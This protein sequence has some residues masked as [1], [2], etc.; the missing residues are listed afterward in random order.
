[1]SWR[2]FLFLAFMACTTVA[3]REWRSADGSRTVEAEFAGMEGDKLLLKGK[4]GKTAAYPASAFSNEDQQFARQAQ[5]IFAAAVSAGALSM[6]VEQLLPEGY[7]CRVIKEL[8]VKKDAWIATGA[9]FL[10]LRGNTF[11]TELGAKVMNQMLYHAGSR[12]LQE[13]D[14]KS[15]PLNAYSVSLDEAVAA[16]RQAALA[17][18]EAA[19]KVQ[20]PRAPLIIVRGMALPLGGPHCIAE[21]GM[22]KGASAITLQINGQEVPASVARMIEPLDVALL[23]CTMD[24]GPRK[25]LPR[26][27]LERGQKIIAVSLVLANDGRSF[28]TATRTTGSISRLVG[29]DLFEHDATIPANSK[30]GYVLDEKGD[31]LGLFFSP[32]SRALGGRQPE[33]AAGTDQPVAAGLSD[34]I[35]I[36]SLDKLFT[37][38]DQRTPGIPWSKPAANGEP[39][40]LAT[41]LLR[42]TSLVI[43]A[44]NEAGG[45][46]A[47]Q[48]AGTQPPADGKPAVTGWSLSSSGTRHNSNCRFYNAAN[49]C[50]AADGKPCKVC[51]G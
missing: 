36:E 9:P 16:S 17:G 24:L 32:Q 41:E 23:S 31:V 30:G 40:S 50:Q 38:S 44:T 22:L 45:T 25:L 33:T 8:P 43:T 49:A 3:A 15:T 18:G 28:A 20:E 6:Q 13:R 35:R 2:N 26:K 5:V 27:P 1:M 39:I 12:T 21:A 42:K 48:T 29:E 11:A 37:D 47:P 10:V 4:D 46:T 34:C 19:P 14:G 51:G 7:L